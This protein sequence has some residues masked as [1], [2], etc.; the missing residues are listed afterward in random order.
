MEKIPESFESADQY[1]GSYGFPLLEEM[2][3]ELASALETVYKAPFAEVTSFKKSK[4]GKLLYDVHVDHWRNEISDRG[5]E[6]YRTLPGDFVLLSELKPASASDLQC[7]GLIYS[8]AFVKKIS[9]DESSHKITPSGFTLKTAASI[10]IEGQ[11]EQIESLYVV[12]LM[13]MTTH[14]RIWNALRMRQNLKIVEKVLTENV[15]VRVL[16]SFSSL[17]V[18]CNWYMLRTYRILVLMV[19]TSTSNVD[20]NES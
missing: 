5:K 20:N 9:E 12:Y 18:F 6:T 14:K 16:H 17:L 15:L 2:R 1:L 11:H 10:D 13:N 7:P 8:F 3:A 19:E 4:L